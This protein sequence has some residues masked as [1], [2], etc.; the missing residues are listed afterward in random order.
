MLVSEFIRRYSS[1][2]PY[3]FKDF[4]GE[5]WE[6]VEA[7]A[8]F[9]VSEIVEEFGDSVMTFQLWLAWVLPFDWEMC[10]PAYVYR[11]YDTRMKTWEDIFS[12]EGLTFHPRYLINGGNYAREHKRSAALELAKNEQIS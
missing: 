5:V 1:G 7:C 8:K 4:V 12:K 10:I 11:K 3:R 9:D 2:T 6:F